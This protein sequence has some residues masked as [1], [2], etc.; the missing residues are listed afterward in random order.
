MGVFLR[1][2]PVCGESHIQRN[3]NREVRTVAPWRKSFRRP[4]T[5]ACKIT[6]FLSKLCCATPFGNT[7]EQ[8]Q[9]I[10]GWQ[11]AHG[12]FCQTLRN[13]PNHK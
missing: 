3:V 1:A 11:T 9:A 7:A 10:A 6:P 2:H 5:Q 13:L 8:H 4:C 12:V